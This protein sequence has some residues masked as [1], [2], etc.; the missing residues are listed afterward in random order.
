MKCRLA[1]ILFLLALL[2][3]PAQAGII[4]GKKGKKPTPTERVPQLVTTLRT[5]GDEHKR[6]QAAEELREH[7]P[8]AFPDIVPVL[9]ESLL[10]DKKAAVRAEAAQTLGGC[11]RC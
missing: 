8:A 9:I 3:R 7:D 5:D 6:A 4:F 1:L 2:A 11:A 10:T